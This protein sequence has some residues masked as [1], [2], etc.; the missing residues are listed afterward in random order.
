[1]F[2]VYILYSENFNRYYIG[3]TNNISNRLE[4]HNSGYV[5]STKPYLPWKLLL[6]L[7][8]STRSEAMILEKKLKNLNTEDLRKFITKYSV[9]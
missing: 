2:Y 1:M 8:K 6:F 7:K 9:G 5:L 3:Q 4:S